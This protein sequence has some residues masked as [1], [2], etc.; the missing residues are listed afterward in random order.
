MTI[1]LGLSSG[2]DTLVAQA[3]GRG[4]PDLVALWDVLTQYSEMIADNL[5]IS[6]V[7]K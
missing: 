6:T 7:P 2:I 5:G 1:S 3:H 4:D